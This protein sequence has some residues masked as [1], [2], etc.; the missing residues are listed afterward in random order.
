MA[1]GPQEG[2]RRGAPRMPRAAPA[3]RLF[4]VARARHAACSSTGGHSGSRARW[5]PRV[6]LPLTSR[7]GDQTTLPSHPGRSVCLSLAPQPACQRPGLPDEPAWSPA[8]G[9]SR[10]PASASGSPACGCARSSG[11]SRQPSPQ[12]KGGS[13]PPARAH[14]SRGLR[15]VAASSRRGV[16]GHSECLHAQGRGSPG[17]C[18]L[19]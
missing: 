7:G 13:D 2:A 17:G 15:R 5:L 3:L 16:G 18:P 1:V 19:K 10:A 9:R 12:A 8:A 14:L 11:G 4:P 6:A